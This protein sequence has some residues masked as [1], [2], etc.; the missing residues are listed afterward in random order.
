MLMRCA[1]IHTSDIKC[2]DDSSLIGSGPRVRPQRVTFGADPVA[3][4]AVA[5]ALLK[6]SR[7]TWMS[8][9]MGVVI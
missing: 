1:G 5:S 2:S 6:C 9:Q 4:W 3:V 7:L 8:W